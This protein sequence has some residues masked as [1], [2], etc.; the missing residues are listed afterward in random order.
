MKKIRNPAAMA[1]LIVFEGIDGSGKT[2][3]SKLLLNHL[4]AAGVPA[5]WLRE[6][7]DSPLGERIRR[8][9][10]ENEHVTPQRELDLFVRDRRQDVRRNILPALRAGRTVVLDRYFYSNA[11]Y[12]GARG[13]D[14]QAI[15]DLNLSFAPPPD[16]TF[17]IDVDVDRALARISGSRAA[18]DK[19]FE[20]KDFLLKVRANY[21]KLT[22]P[23]FVH[24]DGNRGLDLV[25]SEVLDR[26][27]HAAVLEPP[28]AGTR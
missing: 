18:P 4:L 11:C 16:L 10:R 6:P 8:L 23:A 17:I 22:G 2:S 15:I 21:L 13:L 12:Q 26:Y 1:Q 19:L 9:A 14:M 3:L 25:F 24:I 7:S 28:G 5:V 20:K 27:Q